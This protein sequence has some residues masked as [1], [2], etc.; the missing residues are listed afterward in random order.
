MLS[1]KALSDLIFKHEK[2]GFTCEHDSFYHQLISPE[3]N[4]KPFTRNFG[5]IFMFCCNSKL[6]L[7]SMLLS[8][9]WMKSNTL[10]FIW[11]ICFMFI[12]SNSCL[13]MIINH[14]FRFLVLNFV[15]NSFFKK[16]QTR[17]GSDQNQYKTRKMSR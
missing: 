17:F 16:F 15:R 13:F 7:N 4:T 8:W 5:L 12:R 10:I 6:C 9:G 11:F 14:N 1:I 3:G 2:C